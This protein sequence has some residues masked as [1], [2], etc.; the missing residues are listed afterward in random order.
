MPDRG[1]PCQGEA[2]PAGVDAE[3]PIWHVLL[4]PLVI[5]KRRRRV[6]PLSRPALQGV[7]G[8]AV[9]GGQRVSAKTPAVVGK[10]PRPAQGKLSRRRRE[11]L[12][13]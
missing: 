12:R 2:D 5:P 1:S 9:P 10:T 3:V 4:V 13:S 7:E 6:I 8:V 11:V